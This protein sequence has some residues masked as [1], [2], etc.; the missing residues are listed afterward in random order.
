MGWDKVWSMRVLVL[1]SR[2]PLCEVNP[3]SRVATRI[4]KDYAV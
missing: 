1:C 2:I 3:R 4:F